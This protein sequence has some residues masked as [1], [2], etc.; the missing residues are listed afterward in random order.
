VEKLS[1]LQRGWDLQ[2]MSATDR[3]SPSRTEST[4]SQELLWHLKQNMRFGQVEAM[5]E[6]LSC[7]RRGLTDAQFHELCDDLA[8]D[9]DNYGDI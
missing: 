8:R 9:L 1:A 2:S 5:R 4:L 3:T 6:G 7:L